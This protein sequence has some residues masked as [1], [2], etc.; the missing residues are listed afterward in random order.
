MSTL[1]AGPWVGEFGHELFSWQSYV[2]K[3]S[4]SYK[5]TVVACRPGHEVFYADFCSEFRHHE[6]PSGPCSGRTN[7]QSGDPDQHVTA[8]FGDIPYLHILHPNSRFS[9]KPQDQEFAKYGTRGDS[10]F[11]VLIHA[12]NIVLDPTCQIP[13]DHRALKESRN[14]PLAN[15]D[16]LTALLSDCGV[17]LAAIGSPVDA[18]LPPYTFDLRGIPLEELTDRIASCEL[19][20]GPSSGPMHLASLC[21][22]EQLVWGIE[23]LGHRYTEAWNP[24]RTKVW[25]HPTDTCW[26]PNVSDIFDLACK[27][28]A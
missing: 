1:V 14:W 11:D 27:A 4:R 21:G 18:Y 22:T 12:R 6:A 24:F 8:L 17:R 9:G 3:L 7:Y 2:R 28:L 5:R 23:S 26:N 10:D 16:R 25:F 20:L 13:A 15:W 19:V